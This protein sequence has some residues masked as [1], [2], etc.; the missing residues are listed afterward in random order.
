[1]RSSTQ[2]STATLLRLAAAV[3]L[4]AGVLGANLLGVLGASVLAGSAQAQQLAVPRW[5]R[6]VEVIRPGTTVRA[7][8]STESA[9]RGTVQVGTRVP[10][11]SRVLGEGCPGGEWIQIGAEAFVCET[12]VR[13]SPAPPEGDTLPRLESGA[14]TPR[15]HA[16]VATDGTWAYARPEDYFR[17]V[18]VES[19][20]RGFGVAIVERREVR[21]VEMARTLSGLWIAARELRWARPSDFEGV[22]INDANPLDAIG[23]V[24]HSRAP[25]RARPRGRTV[26][27]ATRLALVHVYEEQGRFLRIGD[28]QWISTSHVARPR[29]ATVPEEVAEG[30]RWID[31]DTQRQ[32]MTAYVGDR[33]VYATAVST[34]RGR[35][36]TPR[37]VHRIWVKLAEDNMDNLER[38]DVVENYAIQA[39]PWVQYFEGGNGFHAA[40]W[41]DRF[42]NAR[43]HGCV[44]LAPTDAR[45]LF[46]FTQPGLPP[47]WDAVLSHGRARGTVV[48]VR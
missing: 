6:S 46:E 2:P 42:G 45:W 34:G 21:G 4:S 44:N 33:P 22:E 5:V 32:V 16:F 12:L 23:W 43:S 19:L 15:A 29:P 18:W 38:E 13:Y 41:H 24:V 1:M 20:G 26:G 39:V 40:F 36:P 35:T 3:S 8:P 25:L 48:R 10:L 47:G 14:L 31:V 27:R 30:A 9:R 17:D 7:G 11:I 28:E 37:G